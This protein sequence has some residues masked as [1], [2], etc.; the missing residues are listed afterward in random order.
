MSILG[1]Q[2]NLIIRD[3][4]KGD[5]ARFK[6]LYNLTANHLKVVAYLYAE[7]KND[8]EDIVQETFERAFKYIHTADLKQDG[9]NWLCKITQNVAMDYRQHIEKVDLDSAFFVGEIDEFLIEKSALLYEISKL[10]QKDR[11]MI[12]LMYWGN[13]SIREIAQIVNM[14]KSYVH[15]RIHEIE[16]YLEKKLK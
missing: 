2:V 6:D 11:R 13:L 3:I 10:P 9:Y 12:N 5:K 15:K 8:V 7:D 1:D 4:Q 16:K 14:S